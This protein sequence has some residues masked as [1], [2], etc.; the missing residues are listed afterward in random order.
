VDCL[1]D[2]PAPR[3]CLD[4]D[5]WYFAGNRKCE[6]VDGAYLKPAYL[7]VSECAHLAYTEAFP[8]GLCDTAERTVRKVRRHKLVNVLDAIVEAETLNRTLCEN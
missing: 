6:L 7:C 8:G 1:P 5:L 4:L 2:L 3:P